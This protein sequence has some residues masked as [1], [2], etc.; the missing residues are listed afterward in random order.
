[1][2]LGAAVA[3]EAGGGAMRCLAQYNHTDALNK[4]QRQPLH[5]CRHCGVIGSVE[6]EELRLVWARM[7]SLS[8]VDSSALVSNR[9]VFISS[10]VS[11][12]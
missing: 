8:L 6:S 7:W 3:D 10:E 12:M 5:L 11:Q 4:N 9:I 2:P 1:M